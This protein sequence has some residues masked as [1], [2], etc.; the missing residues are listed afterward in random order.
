MQAWRGGTR[1]AHQ[2]LEKRLDL[3]RP[4]IT[5]SQ[6]SDLLAMFFG[7]YSS[8]EKVLLD[9]G[10]APGRYLAARRP[11]LPL[12]QA[13]L[14]ALGMAPTALAQL[15]LAP[16]QPFWRGEPLRLWGLLYVMEG[17]ALGGQIIARQLGP[18]LQLEPRAGLSFF[19]GRGAGTGASWR[20]FGA[21]VRALSLT[22]RE[23][24]EAV[25]GAQQAFVDLESWSC[26]RLP[27]F[28]SGAR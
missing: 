22:P 13:D 24:R 14:A 18:R 26:E 5:R 16:V 3:L 12:L 20:A 11:R 2:A 25:R 4:E 10:G 19:C 17:A 28:T 7:F 23:L 1:A 27:H 9:G 15:P 6:Y 21:Q 8:F